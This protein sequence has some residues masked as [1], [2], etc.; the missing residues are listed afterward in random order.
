MVCVCLSVIYVLT[1]VCP[2]PTSQ[3]NMAPGSSPAQSHYL[4]HWTFPG[5]IFPS[6]HTP[7]PV[8]ALPLP[9][10]YPAHARAAF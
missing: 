7:F 1:Q 6:I 2:H 3:S 4:P 8:A 10:P 9:L 5:Q